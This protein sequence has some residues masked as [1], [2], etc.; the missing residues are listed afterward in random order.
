MASD[1]QQSFLGEAEY[2]LLRRER[3]PQ[4]TDDQFAVFR[5]AIERFRLDP[6]ANQIYAVIRGPG[7]TVQTGIDGF[8]LVADRTGRYAGNDDPAFDN[9]VKPTKATV[10]V[11]KIVGN[12]RCPFT[13][14]A[15]WEQY[16]P[17]ERQGMMWKRMPHLMLGKCAEALALRKAFPAELSGLYTNEE[18]QQADREPAA[19]EPPT[20]SG[21]NGNGRNKADA[22]ASVLRADAWRA[23]ET[24]EKPRALLSVAENVRDS[25]G[26]PQE[27]RMELMNFAR[28]RMW[29]FAQRTIKALTTPQQAED[30][31]KWYGGLWL[32]TGEQKT[33][34]VAALG[35]VRDGL[36]NNQAGSDAREVAAAAS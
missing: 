1:S 21:G 4:F 25:K 35:A 2:T 34:I 15:R 22:K 29:D 36:Q 10:T 28:E 26:L 32:L 24:A 17:G 31:A 13:A 30:G 27:S 19:T 3:C 9:E 11:Y 14:S 8:R 16:F 5:H 6:F 7:M 23:I 18:L 33:Q 12:Q 20:D